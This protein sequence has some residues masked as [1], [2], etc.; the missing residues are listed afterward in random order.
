MKR[1]FLAI[2]IFTSGI[3]LSQAQSD[4]E[5]FQLGAKGGVNIANFTGNDFGEADSRTSFNVGLLMEIPL[6]ER[7]SLQPEVLYSGQGFDI[8]SIDEDNFLDNDE[9]IEYQLDY[10]QVPVLAKVYLVDGLSIEAGPTFSF[11]VN[12]EIDYEPN[13]DDG[14]IDID[15]D[16]SAV[17]DFD[18]GLAAGASYKFG[19]SFFVSGRY[20]YGFTKIF[21]DSDADVRNSVW[22]FGIGFMF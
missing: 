13:N 2:A 1:F 17:K 8:Q 4:S 16:V 18:F 14:D 9:N 7:F 5:M 20:N 15:D 21:E 22:Q 3:Y 10:L 6:S 11:K 19:T 12:E